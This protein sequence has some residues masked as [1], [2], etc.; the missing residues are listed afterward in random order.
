MWHWLRKNVGC[1]EI[2]PDTSIWIRI[3]RLGN[4]WIQFILLFGGIVWLLSCVEKLRV[5]SHGVLPQCCFKIPLVPC[6]HFREPQCH[7]YSATSTTTYFRSATVSQLNFEGHKCRSLVP[8]APCRRSWTSAAFYKCHECR[9]SVIGR[10]SANIIILAPAALYHHYCTNLSDHPTNT[11]HLYLQI[12][13]GQPV[14]HTLHIFTSSRLI[15]WN[16]WYWLHNISMK[17]RFKAG[18]RC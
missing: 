15:Y 11:Q 12:R 10:P 17:P 3:M 14:P 2:F 4:F 5:W 1:F 7:I 6:I 9:R 16:R 18:T 13:D 8:Q